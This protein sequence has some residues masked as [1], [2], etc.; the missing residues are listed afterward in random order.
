MAAVPAQLQRSSRREGIGPAR[1]PNE[2]IAVVLAD[3]SVRDLRGDRAG[4]SPAARIRN[5]ILSGP[6]WLLWWQRRSF[7]PDAAPTPA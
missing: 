3:G 5:G 2:V 1:D 6:D 4:A 7:T